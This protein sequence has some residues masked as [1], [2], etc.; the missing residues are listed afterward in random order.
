[1]TS[2]RIYIIEFTPQ[3]SD[4][5]YQAQT[6]KPIQDLVE[7]ASQYKQGIGNVSIRPLMLNGRFM[8]Y[9][10]GRREVI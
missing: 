4:K 8:T 7:C 2:Q 10:N 5:K 1:M 3:G 9:R 6:M